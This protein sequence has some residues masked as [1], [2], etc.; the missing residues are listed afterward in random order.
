MGDALPR[1]TPQQRKALESKLSLFPPENPTIAQLPQQRQMIPIGSASGSEFETISPESIGRD[2]SM[3]RLPTGEGAFQAMRAADWAVGASPRAAL[4]AYIDAVEEN[5]RFPIIDASAAFIKQFGNKPESSPTGK[6]LARKLGISDRDFSET[7]AGGTGSLAG[8]AGVGI[9][10]V[11]DLSNLLGLGAAAGA[12]KKTRGLGKN[13]SRDALFGLKE[14]TEQGIV[15]KFM[16]KLKSAFDDEYGKFGDNMMNAY[17][18]FAEAE[19]P[20]IQESV[21]WI[22][23]NA[24]EAYKKLLSGNR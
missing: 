15:D 19:F 3:D 22:K 17:R 2:P 24:P 7:G 21:G 12:L 20:T 10:G 5:K 11:L 4:E 1:L 13:L 6:A 23:E 8:A 14:G 18:N 16:K 9:E